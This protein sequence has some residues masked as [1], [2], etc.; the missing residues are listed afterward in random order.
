MTNEVNSMAKFLPQNA[1][2]EERRMNL[3]IVEILVN[4]KKKKEQ[5]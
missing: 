2:I 5:D 3:T 1:L 4:Q